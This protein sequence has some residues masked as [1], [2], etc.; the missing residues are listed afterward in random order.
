M[1]LKLTRDFFLRRKGRFILAVLAVAFLVVA[2]LFM[3]S[4]ANG[5]RNNAGVPD[6]AFT[7]QVVGEFKFQYLEDY[8]PRFPA[9]FQNAVAEKA[10]AIPATQ[11]FMLSLNNLYGT[12]RFALFGVPQDFIRAYLVPSIVS[13][14]APAEGEAAVVLGHT[15][16]QTFKVGIGDTLS[17]TL[18]DAQ[19]Q[20][21]RP[22]RVVGILDPAAHTFFDQAIFLPAEVYERETQQQS[23]P[24][25][26]LVYL[27][28]GVKPEDIESAYRQTPGAP[29]GFSVSTLKAN[30]YSRI[31]RLVTSIFVVGLCVLSLYQELKVILSQSA[32]QIGLLKAMGMSDFHV[33]LVFAQGV[34]AIFLI[35][36]AL[37][38]G[39]SLPLFSFL[40]G[41]IG[42]MLDAQVDIYQLTVSG[43]LS[44]AY[45]FLAAL[46]L[47]VL[48]ILYRTHKVPPRVALLGI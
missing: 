45:I 31:I 35:A 39:L 34:L 37:G 30:D 20:D 3:N 26:I 36:C 14:S 46:V 21:T 19:D 9:A 10:V 48:G 40:N 23:H 32:R 12:Y 43:V 11:R 8:D 18:S 17:L 27:K 47:V 33:T 25:T 24:N 13:G 15:A 22:Y 16:A 4:P 29:R 7:T 28:P 38:V 44:V 5:A 1:Y 6:M 42:K 41:Q 2:Y